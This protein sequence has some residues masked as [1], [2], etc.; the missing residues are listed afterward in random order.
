MSEADLG[1]ITAHNIVQTSQMKHHHKQC[2]HLRNRKEEEPLAKLIQLGPKATV[3]TSLPLV[4]P[5]AGK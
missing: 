5:V 4:N 1:M 2:N 3:L